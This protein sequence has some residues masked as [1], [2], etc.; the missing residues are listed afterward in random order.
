MT[1]RITLNHL[2]EQIRQDLLTPPRATS[3][4][5]LYPFL[6]VD[7]IELEVTVTISSDKSAGGKLTVYVV[8]GDASGST[9]NE[10][11]HTVRLKLSPLIEKPEMASILKKDER[12]WEKIIGTTKRAVNK[13]I[14]LAGPPE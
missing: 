7:E 1:K 6:F 10:Q 5:D 3:S 13:D 9:S 2:I 14:Q 8:E 12:L 11:S 4:D